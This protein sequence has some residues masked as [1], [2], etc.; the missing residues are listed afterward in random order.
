MENFEID[1]RYIHF[2]HIAGMAKNIQPELHQ[3]QDK[4]W[5]ISQNCAVHDTLNIS[6]IEILLW[7]WQVMAKQHS[8]V[9]P[10][11]KNQYL[12]VIASL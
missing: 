3:F 11:R 5:S 7:Y 4:F 1:E 12:V 8:P 2:D 9:K 6:Q 10:S